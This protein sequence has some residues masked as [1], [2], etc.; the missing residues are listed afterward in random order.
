MKILIVRFSAIGDCVMAGVAVNDI[1]RTVQGAEVHWAVADGCQDVIATPKTVLPRKS[2]KERGEFRT[3]FEQFR[4]HTQLRKNQFDIGFDLQG[5]SKTAWCL[6][7]S[8]AKRHLS[9]RATDAIAQ[10]LNPHVG[11]SRKEG[12]HEIEW[13]RDVFAHALDST[14][15]TEDFLPGERLERD[16][17]LVTIAVG[18]GH[19]AKTIPKQTLIAVGS[20]LAAQGKTVLYLGGPHDTFDPPR[21]TKSLVGKTTLTDTLNLVRQ[22]SL[23]ICGDTGTGHMA[24]VTRTPLVCVWG[25]MPLAQFRP[26][27]DL[28]AVIDKLGEPSRV[29]AEEIVEAAKSVS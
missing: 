10:R 19:P 27:T 12:L 3:L 1:V 26:Y 25:N 21:D 16:P 15:V 14:P 20:A 29:T 18:T 24:A 11:V 5:H 7:L 2:W 4:W 22:S 8:G 23:H 17:N 6:R 13:Y 9:L 28:V